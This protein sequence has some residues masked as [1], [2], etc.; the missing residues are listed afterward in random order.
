MF[1]KK[2]T[3]VLAIMVGLLVLVAACAAPPTAENY[4]SYSNC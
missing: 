3:L 1:S 2:S 4:Y